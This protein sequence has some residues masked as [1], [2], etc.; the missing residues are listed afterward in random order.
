MIHPSQ[1]KEEYRRSYIKRRITYGF[2]IKIEKKYVQK[3]AHPQCLKHLRWIFHTP[4]GRR[5]EFQVLK[6]TG[7]IGRYRTLKEAIQ[8]LVRP[9][10][11]LL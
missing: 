10:V 11:Q 9:S 4:R 3:E 8:A 2:Q 6:M 7:T 1:K 5:H